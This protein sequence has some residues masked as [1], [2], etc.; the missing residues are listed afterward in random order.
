M[1]N[2]SLVVGSA[3]P[4]E[5][6]GQNIFNRKIKKITTTKSRSS[7]FPCGFFSYTDGFSA[8]TEPPSPCKKMNVH[9]LFNIGDSAHSQ[10]PLSSHPKKKN[11]QNIG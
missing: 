4:A 9:S 8:L 1:P 10:L 3:P 6:F 11:A 7:R 5:T 2:S